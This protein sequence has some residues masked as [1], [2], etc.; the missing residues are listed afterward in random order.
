MS[1]YE[2]L[3]P[4]MDYLNCENF[5]F[6]ESIFV[7]RLPAQIFSDCN[8]ELRNNLEAIF[9][10]YGESST[11]HYLPSVSR[12]CVVFHRP[13]EASLAKEELDKTEFL[14]YGCIKVESLR[15]I[16]TPWDERFLKVPKAKR[17]FLLSPPSS[18]PVGWEP[19][20]EPPPVPPGAL[21]SA[22][23]DLA[24]CSG[25]SLDLHESE[26]PSHPTIRLET[27]VLESDQSDYSVSV[28]AVRTCRP[29]Y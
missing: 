14:D 24:Y 3:C 22:L 10:R 6:E 11:F 2:Y 8:Q 25:I 15:L 21:E 27:V 5:R 16:S 13:G 20:E 26:N 9:R 29:S 4:E 1:A 18:P 12:V 7:S 28:S 19:I 17:S 23:F